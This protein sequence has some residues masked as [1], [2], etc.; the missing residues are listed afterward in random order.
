[1]K[2]VRD[3]IFIILA[4]LLVGFYA[5]SISGFPLDDSWIHQVYGRNLAQLGQWAF[6]PDVPSSASTAPFYTVLLAIG[7]ALNIPYMFWTHALGALALAGSGIIGARMA[8]MLYPKSAY[9]GWATG[10]ALITSWH[11]IWAGASGMETMLFC[12]LLLMGM[13]LAWRE[14]A[15]QRDMRM[16]SIILRGAVFGLVMALTTATRPEGVLLAVTLG[17]MMHIARPHPHFRHTVLWGIGAG[18]TFL[19]AMSP[20]LLLNLS[21]N[22][23]LLPNTSDAK[24]A[25][26]QPLLALPYTTRLVNIIPPI[27]AGAQIFF[28]LT[29]PY[30]MLMMRRYGRK[31]S[32]YLAPL[33]WAMALILLYAARLPVS[34][35]HGRYLIPALPMIIVCGVIGMVTMLIEWRTNMLGR[36]VSRALALAVIPTIL[37]FAISIGRDAYI[38]DVAIINEEMV[39]LAL[40]IRDNLPQDELLAIH[41]VGAV[42]Y[43]AP[44]PLVDIAGLITPEAIPLIN[45]ADALWALMRERGATYLMA[46]PNQIP[47]KNPNDWRLCPVYQSAGETTPRL[48]EAKMT[49]YRLNWDKSSC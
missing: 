24:Y 44:R 21:L 32:L 49:I 38:T 16:R 33:I 8:D 39:D 6:I 18:M 28:L 36:V 1:M 40:W 20:Y 37:F 19:V 5:M 30:Y 25:Q 3:I 47:N 15:P 26:A 41:D 9:V 29:I 45:N 31:A 22:G 11:L 23:S 42:G 7:Y 13:W 4:S 34:F 27:L 14:L 43:F 12:T 46:F 10:L 35:Q 2:F 17:S 48:G